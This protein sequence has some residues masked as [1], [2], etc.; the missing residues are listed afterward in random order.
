MIID[1]FSRWVHA[2]A[3]NWNRA[4][5]GEEFRG[6]TAANALNAFKEFEAAFLQKGF[7]VVGVVTDSGSQARVQLRTF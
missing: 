3:F 7:P 4:P 6:I 1:T 5:R 2:K